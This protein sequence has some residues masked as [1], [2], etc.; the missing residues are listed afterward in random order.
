MTAGWLHVTMRALVGGSDPWDP[1]GCT[2]DTP[3]ATAAQAWRGSEARTP[4]PRSR[5]QTG[6]LPARLPRWAGASGLATAHAAS[7]RKRATGVKPGAIRKVACSPDARQR[8]D[9][10]GPVTP[11]EVEAVLLDPEQVLP[12]AR[13][14]RWV[15]ERRVSVG[16]RSQLLRVIYELDATGTATLLTFYLTSKVGKYWRESP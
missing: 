16:G 8:L 15:V 6:T 14:G 12:T 11:A 9:E 10:R 13:P 7:P 4:A 3:F 1:Y 5:S 2:G